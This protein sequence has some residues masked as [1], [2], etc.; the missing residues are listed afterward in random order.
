MVC[1]V[2]KECSKGMQ[3]VGTYAWLLIFSVAVVGFALTAHHE[4]W[5]L[6]RWGCLALSGVGLCGSWSV[7]DRPLRTIFGKSRGMYTRRW[8]IVA[9]GLGIFAAVVYRCW[10]L[11][12]APFLD[13]LH[14]F[15]LTAMVI[16]LTEELLWRGWMQ[17]VLTNT[18]GPWLALSI[19]AVSHAAYKTALFVFP[20]ID[21]PMRTPG[22]LLSMAAITLVA[23]LFLGFIRVREGTIAAPVAFHMLFD[24]FV[25]GQCATTPWW[26]W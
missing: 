11:K 14:A 3:R 7:M 8:I 5:W 17:G 21:E 24:L 13:V 2:D 10:L 20:P 18:L 22:S 26:V 16:G 9:G 25:Y 4:A 23:G 15:A 19:V 12:T 6:W 1:A